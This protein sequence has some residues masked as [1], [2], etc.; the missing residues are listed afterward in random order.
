M[1]MAKLALQ[2][3][4]NWQEIMM[5][6]K[7]LLSNYNY[8]IIH[9]NYVVGKQPALVVGARQSRTDDITCS[10]CCVCSLAVCVLCA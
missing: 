1:I 3:I 9:S 4:T 2:K 10:M 8:A 5:I 6:L 7:V